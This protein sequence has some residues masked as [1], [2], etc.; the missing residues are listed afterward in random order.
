ML[1]LISIHTEL[2]LD[3]QLSYCYLSTLY[4]MR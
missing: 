4:V 3:A 2:L 1:P